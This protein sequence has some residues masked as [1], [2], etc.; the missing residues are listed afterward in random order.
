[1]NNY[2]DT[3]LKKDRL[4]ILKQKKNF[5]FNKININ[6]YSKLKNFLTI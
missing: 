3:N 6:N 1:M 5:S 2:Y 4:K